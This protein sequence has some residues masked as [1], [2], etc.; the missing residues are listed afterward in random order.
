MIWK[1]RSITLFCKV[2]PLCLLP[3]ISDMQ[4]QNLFTFS[5]IDPHRCDIELW[6]EL[7][8]RSYWYESNYTMWWWLLLSTIIDV[9]QRKVIIFVT[10]Q[11]A[12]ISWFHW[13]ELLWNNSTWKHPSRFSHTRRY[14]KYM[15]DAVKN[16]SWHGRTWFTYLNTFVRRGL[17]SRRRPRSLR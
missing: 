10:Q 6:S 4:P 9:F 1:L 12:I 7:I 13:K 2:T 14:D 5:R 8:Q 3:P 16:S 11:W 15:E 17:I